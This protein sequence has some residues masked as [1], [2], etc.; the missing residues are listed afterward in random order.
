M[1]MTNCLIPASS[2]AL[3]KVT[4][5]LDSLEKWREIPPMKSPRSTGFS[6]IFKSKIY[7]FGGYTGEKKR[8]K[9]IEV[10]DPIKN[11]WEC[12]NVTTLIFRLSYIAGS[13][14]ALFSRSNLM[15]S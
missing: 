13:K 5:V 11:Y 7:V 1:K 14:L 9:M 10:Y 8:S 12:L 6:L 2:T 15:K 3:N 4:K